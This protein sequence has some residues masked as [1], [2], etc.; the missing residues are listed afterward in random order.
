MQVACEKTVS[1]MQHVLQRTIKS[2][3]G[4][5]IQ[6][7]FPCSVWIGIRRDIQGDFWVSWLKAEA[8]REFP[9]WELDSLVCMFLLCPAS[10]FLTRA[11]CRCHCLA[12]ADCAWLSSAKP[13]Q[14]EE[15]LSLVCQRAPA[16]VE[17]T[18]CP[19]ECV[20][21]TERGLP[22]NNSFFA[23][24]AHVRSD[25]LQL[26]SPWSSHLSVLKEICGF[27]EHVCVTS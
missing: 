19:S 8:G 24:L 22:T 12:C 10:P 13:A 17:L 16:S 23:V 4:K 26:L 1:A 20:F 11:D 14:R 18:H 3:K 2:A 6:T 9:E 5:F 15:V 7:L 27:S 25:F 21:S